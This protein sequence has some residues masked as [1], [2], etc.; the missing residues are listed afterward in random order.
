MHLSISVF[1]DFRLVQDSITI[2]NI[3]LLG[4]LGSGS[5]SR[6]ERCYDRRV[7]TR[8]P[9]LRPLRKNIPIPLSTYCTQVSSISN[10][11]PIAVHGAHC[12]RGTRG[13]LYREKN[14]LFMHIT[15]FFATGGITAKTNRSRVKSADQR[16]LTPLNYP[17]TGSAI[18]VSTVQWFR[19]RSNQ[20]YL[21]QKYVTKNAV[22]NP[23]FRHP[24]A[25]FQFLKC[26][27]SFR[28]CM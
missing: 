22:S 13:V 28:K 12:T 18:L 2:P 23:S 21:T 4:Y 20:T 24:F 7:V 8:T 6:Y 14:L 16:L 27:N 3:W 17:N 15:Y 19:I 1:G 11:L 26:V 25:I 10:Y 9:L 5:G